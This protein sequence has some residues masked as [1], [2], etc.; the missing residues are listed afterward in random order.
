MKDEWQDHLFAKL[1]ESAHLSDVINEQLSHQLSL[2]LTFCD[3]YLPKI[4]FE[5]RILYDTI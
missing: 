1:L 2:G 4:S 3:S 5:I